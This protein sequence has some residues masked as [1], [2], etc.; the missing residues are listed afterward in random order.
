MH[1]RVMGLISGQIY[2]QVANNA[3]FSL[4]SPPLPAPLSHSLINGKAYS[5]VR[6]REEGRKLSSEGGNQFLPHCIGSYEVF[7][8]W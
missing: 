7:G 3:Y 6:T 2:T 4:L 8:G 1:E 5:Q